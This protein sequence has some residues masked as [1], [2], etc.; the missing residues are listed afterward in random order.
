MLAASQSPTISTANKSSHPAFL[1][2]LPK[3]QTHAQIYFRHIPCAETKA[4]KIA[5]TLALAWKWFL[6]LH[7]RG[8]DISQFSMVFIYLVAKAVKSG[9]RLCGMEK[10]K[11]VMSFFAQQ[12]GGFRVEPLPS[13]TRRSHAS[14]YSLIR[15]Q[16]EAGAYEERLKDN[17]ATPPPDAAAF[18]VDFPN[19]L[20]DLPERDREMAMYLSLGHRANKA[21]AKFGL[22]PGRVTQLRQAWCREWRASQ[23]EDD[24]GSRT[25]RK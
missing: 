12:R 18:R 21:A 10:A 23:G 2:L 13:S 15:G 24:L 19:F 20:H 1:A 17:T 6:R 4:E 14:I 25:G 3:L 7:E 11:D 9:R 5:E 8:I 22:S 16:Q